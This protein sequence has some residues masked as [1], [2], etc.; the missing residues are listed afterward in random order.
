MFIS[1]IIM[2][3]QFLGGIYKRIGYF[4]VMLIFRHRH[5]EQIY[6]GRRCILKWI[7]IIRSQFRSYF[8]TPQL[9]NIE[10]FWSNMSFYTGA[11]PHIKARFSVEIQILMVPLGTRIWRFLTFDENK[12]GLTVK[13][14]LGAL[15]LGNVC[16]TI[17]LLEFRSEFAEFIYSS[18]RL[19]VLKLVQLITDPWLPGLQC[20]G[21]DL[22][23]NNVNDHQW[24]WD[25]NKSIK[26]NK[27]F[28][29][30]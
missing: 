7:I 10:S 21:S 23:F 26:C 28:S 18:S 13:E 1:T 15:A 24:T 11:S 25:L 5:S 17:N 14:G 9:F 19:F 20:C 4:N 3:L 22:G 27:F 2:C 12:L 8:K 16:N 29:K 6:R 30:G